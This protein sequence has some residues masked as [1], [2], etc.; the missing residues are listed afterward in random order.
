MLT[1]NCA[2]KGRSC[3]GWERFPGEGAI[4][5]GLDDRVGILWLDEAGDSLAEGDSMHKSR[6]GKI[7]WHFQEATLI[8][9]MQERNERRG[10]R[11]LERFCRPS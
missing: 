7:A 2:S 6:R 5:H 10:Q 9:A 8:D 3:W 11:L 1:A 4:E